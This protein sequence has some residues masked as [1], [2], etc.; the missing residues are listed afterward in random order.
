MTS[1]TNE[2]KAERFVRL[3]EQRVNKALN[4]LRLIE[5]L[6]N[7][8]N[9][10]YSEEQA[11]QII[12]ALEDGLKSIKRSFRNQDEIEPSSFRLKK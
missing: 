8:K 2:D 11:Q 7:R 4:F 3:A 10:S 6:S 12:L 1:T 9:Y 5:N